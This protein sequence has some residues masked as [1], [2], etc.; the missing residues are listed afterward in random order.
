MLLYSNVI[1]S[2]LVAV[3]LFLMRSTAENGVIQ[4]FTLYDI[5]GIKLFARDMIFFSTSL[6]RGWVNEP[7]PCQYRQES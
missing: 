6:E 5:L 7:H 2:R 4:I 3:M 1:V